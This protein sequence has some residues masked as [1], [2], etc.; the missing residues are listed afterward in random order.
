MDSLTQATL[1]A[2]IGEVMLGKKLGHKAWLLG[3][4]GGTIPDLDVLVSPFLS[5]ID[6]IAWHRGYSH[7]ILV[8]LLLPFFLTWIIRKK[9]W[10]SGIDYFQLWL[11]W[12]LTLF[13]HVVL[14]GFTSYGTLLFLPFA[15]WRVSFNS[16]NLVDPVYTVPLLLG[17]IGTMIERSRKKESKG[18]S[19]QMG[20]VISTIYLLFTL[21]HKKQIDRVFS[22]ELFTLDL[23]TYDLLTVP[24]GVG[25]IQ[26]YGVAKTQDALYLGFYS[27]LKSNNI[28]FDVF[29]VNEELLNEIDPYLAERMRWF[30]QDFYTVVKAGKKIRFY[31][32]QCDM[33]GPRDLGEYVA[34]TAFYFEIEPLTDGLFNISTGMHESE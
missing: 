26:W 4:I 9:P 13:T 23:P 19:N 21:A 1:G 27:A 7:S 10:G 24:V 29:P 5:T 8:G 2:A 20:L 33:Q 30:A 17:L 22:S 12:F 25:N 34:P 18:L 3:A 31:N 15:D 11:F 32:L 16:I 6:K 28:T 14:D